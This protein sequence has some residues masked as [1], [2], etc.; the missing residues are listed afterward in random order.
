[1][2][3]CDER[4]FCP[5]RRRG[6][7]KVHGKLLLP[8]HASLV[9]MIHHELGDCVI[10]SS[11]CACGRVCCPPWKQAFAVRSCV[12]PISLILFVSGALVPLLQDSVYC[13]PSSTLVRP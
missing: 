8:S 9:M 13:F 12:K 1:M 2:F 4:V 3:T 7:E 5:V 11:I 6:S 10:E